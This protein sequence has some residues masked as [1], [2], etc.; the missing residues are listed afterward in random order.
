MFVTVFFGV[1]CST[2]VPSRSQ[3]FVSVFFGV[4]NVVM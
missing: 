1:L 3:T 4:V 2:G